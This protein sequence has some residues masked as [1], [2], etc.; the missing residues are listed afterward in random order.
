MI[1]TR[2]LPGS[3]RRTATAGGGGPP[4]TLA[5]E[6]A[7]LMGQVA[8]RA[9]DVLAA[10]A[11]RQWPARELHALAGYLRAEL[12]RHAEDEEWRLFRASAATA[13]LAQLGRDHVRLRSLVEALERAADG[14]GTHSRVELAGLTCDLL[15]QLQRHMVAEEAVL[16][17]GTPGTVPAMTSPGTHQ[18][19]WYPLTE[20]PVVDLDALPPD[21]MT[22]AAVDRLQRLRAG[23]RVEFRSSRDTAE[24]WQRMDQL[25]SGGLRVLL[26]ARRSR[27]VARSGHA[28][29]T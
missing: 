13:G 25:E 11:G 15:A 10:T 22:D 14:T 7:L 9:E 8:L 2:E 1:M 28:Q 23:E 12:L 5:R 3:G 21:E 29:A 27:R 16:A 19:R 26:P 17:S 24:I 4:Q 18:H 6:H 20:G